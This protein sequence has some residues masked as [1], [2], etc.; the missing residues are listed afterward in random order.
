MPTVIGKFAVDGTTLYGVGDS[1][2]YR[3]D[4]HSE[5]ELLS[6]DVPDN[7]LS[8]VVSNDRLYVGTHN[9]GMFHISLKERMDIA[10]SF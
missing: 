1:G 9:H 8:L 2:T 3:L 4:A 10:N 5:W 6:A 7:I